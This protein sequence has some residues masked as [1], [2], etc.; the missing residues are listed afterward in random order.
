M[1]VSSP[2][3]RQLTDIELMAH[4]FRRAGFGARREELESALARGYASTVELLLQPEQQPE[5]ELDLVY[6]FYPDMKEAREAEVNQ[7]F[8]LY[9]MINSQRPLE[10]KMALF[11]HSLFATAYSK[12]FHA[13][14]LH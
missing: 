14:M 7:S 3:V 11:W 12:A 13:Q 8:W 6:R 1:A 9:R 5:L 4:L 2:E 10:E